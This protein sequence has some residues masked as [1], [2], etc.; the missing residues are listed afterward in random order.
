MKKVSAYM[1]YLSPTLTLGIF[2]GVVRPHGDRDH[3]PDN[4]SER[5]FFKH[6]SDPG[7]RDRLARLA[8]K[9]H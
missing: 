5:S 9:V 1:T 8:R 7:T 4:A 2:C 3:T 6:A